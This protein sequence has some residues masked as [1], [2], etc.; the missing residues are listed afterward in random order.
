MDRIPARGVPLHRFDGWNAML[1]AAGLPITQRVWTPAR[2][3]AALQ[4]WT[5]ANGRTPR[6][7]DWEGGLHDAYPSPTTVFNHFPGWN[8]MLRA[9]GVQLN[10]RRWTP[11]DI[12]EACGEFERRHGRRVRAR[13]LTNANGLPSPD[14][15]AA[16]IGDHRALLDAL[17][18][19]HAGSMSEARASA[20]VRGT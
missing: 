18:T 17:N 4:A 7:E 6:K 19:W 11:E 8:A 12:L 16:H 1:E 9:G 14:A 2:I 15:V 13:E 5:A 20:G 10:R 3:L